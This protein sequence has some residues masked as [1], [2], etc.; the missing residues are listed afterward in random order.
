MHLK[1]VT[2]EEFTEIRNCYVN[3]IEN[4]PNM[5]KYARWKLGQHPTDKCI[6]EYISKGALYQYTCKDGIGGALALTMEQDK[7][8]GEIT[9]GTKVKD[10]EVAVI[11]ILG[12]NPEF[13]R[14]GI[15]T[16]MMEEA[17]QIARE[18][19]KK[20]LRLDALASNTPAQQMYQ[21]MGFLYRG[22]RNLYAE[23]T[24]WTDFYFYEYLL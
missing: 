23:N 15:G 11:H 7:T 3:M 6:R 22:S 10:E 8:Y 5:E 16:Q 13:Q 12:V 4:T 18:H 20:A 21:R 24:G 2:L 19:G 14:R 1:K 9:W 17:I